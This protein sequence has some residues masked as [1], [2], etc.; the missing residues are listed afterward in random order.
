HTLSSNEIYGKTLGLVGFG[1]IGIRIAEIAKVFNM[2]ICAFDRSPEKPHKKSAAEKMCVKFTD[3][4]TLFKTSDIISIQT[5]L[6]AET[7]NLVD[8]KI[9]AS[10]KKTAMIINVGRG[11]IINED[12]LYEALRDGQIAGAALDVFSE[13]PPKDNPL[14]N[15]RNFVGTPHVGAQ[16]MQAQKKIGDDV[17]AIVDGFEH[18]KDLNDLGGVVV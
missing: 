6:N 9:I 12:A 18:G 10:M 3:I 15:L 2:D 16:T 4:E 7:R 1:R 13:E 17:L 14:L 8:T 5:P 11:K